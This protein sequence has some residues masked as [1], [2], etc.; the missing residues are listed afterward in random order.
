MKILIISY[1]AFPLN[2]V[3]SYRIQSF[4]EGFT[5]EGADVTLLTRHWDTTFKSW[6]DILT[7]QKEP[8]KTIRENGYRQ[9]FLPYTAKPKDNSSRL[10]STLGT[11]KNYLSGNLQSETDAY[12][13]FK[14]YALELLQKEDDFDLILV[15]APPNN[16]VKLAHY[17]NQKTNVPYVVDFRDYLNDQYLAVNKQ[18]NFSSKILNTL[19]SYHLRKWLKKSILVS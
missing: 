8:P 18:L 13:N 10:V 12:A 9:I 4:C 6:E 7:S 16:L 14:D 3:P 17:L 15:S 5:Q 19:T 1:Y 2:A 11:F